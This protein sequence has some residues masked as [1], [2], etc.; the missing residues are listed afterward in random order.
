MDVVI[1][2]GG[3]YIGFN[4]A[5]YL[6]DTFSVTAVISNKVKNENKIKIFNNQ[7]V[8]TVSSIDELINLRFKEGTCLIYLAGHSVSDHSW[9]DISKLSRV[10]IESLTKCL[11][12]ARKHNLKLIIG[13]SYWELVSSSQKS[14]I[15]LYSAFQASENSIVDFY[16]K[17]FGIS[18]V[19][20]FLS[21]IYGPLDW[22][23]KLLPMLI[24]HS[25]TSKPIKLGNPI[26]IIAPI[27]INDVL[28][29]FEKEIEEFKPNNIFSRVQIIPV[30]IYSLSDFVEEFQKISRQRLIIKWSS[31]HKLREDIS[32]YP[33]SE[34]ARKVFGKTAFKQGLTQVLKFNN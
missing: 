29:I 8:I 17:T 32:D 11:D 34:S 26:Q 30:K 28:K 16:V 15:N 1:I 31:I 21:D 5:K 18:V 4:L 19:K 14:F 22:R 24:E 3:G 10:Y 20:M 27:Y 6:S 33:V 13:S 2:G 23:R 12:L 25:H 7:N 9:K